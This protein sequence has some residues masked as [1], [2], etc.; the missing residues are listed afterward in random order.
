MIYM[1]MYI[2]YIYIYIYNYIYII[3]IDF[4]VVTICFIFDGAR[5]GG[6]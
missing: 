3:F 4:Y 6:L 2:Y 5:C 1:I